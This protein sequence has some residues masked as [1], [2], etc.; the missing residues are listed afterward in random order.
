MKRGVRLL[1]LVAMLASLPV[2]TQAA[3]S[4]AAGVVRGFYATLSDTMKQGVQLGFAGRYKKLEPV[5][6]SA[7]DMPA[8]TKMAVGLTWASATPTEQ[9]HLIA[10]FSDFS[11]AN[12]ANQFK[13]DDGEQFLVEGAQP[14]T[15]GVIVATKLTPKDGGPVALNYLVRQDGQGTWRIVDVF[16]NG[17]ISQ[18]AARRS[19]FSA[20]AKRDGLNALVNA[21]SEK[22]KQ[23]D[24]S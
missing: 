9:A 6:K 18:M 22:S 8:M 12:Y 16:L 4:D 23:L 11:V 7:F 17:A 3:D 21:L 15:N 1:M 2:V 19:E 5:I 14:T 20:I 13:T 24:P 10:A